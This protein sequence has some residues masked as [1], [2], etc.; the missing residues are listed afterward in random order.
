M[1]TIAAALGSVIGYLGAEVATE[2][3]FERLLWPERYYHDCTLLSTLKLSFLMAMGGPLHRAALGTLQIFQQNGLY[4]GPLRGKMLGTAFY[5][6]GTEFYIPRSNVS[7]QGQKKEVRNCLWIEVL[8]HVKG[9]AKGE[10]FVSTAQNDKK[11]LHEIQMVFQL[12]LRALT[13]RDD[14]A[15]FR[16]IEE[17][18]ITWRV[19]LGIICSELSGIAVAICTAIFFHYYWLTA[20]FCLPLVFKL[21]ALLFR[22]RRQPLDNE[23]VTSYTEDASGTQILNKF[24]FVNVDSRFIVIESP[25]VVFRQFVRHYGHP[26]R[27]GRRILDNEQARLSEARRGKSKAEEESEPTNTNFDPWTFRLD[28]MRPF[29]NIVIIYAFVLYFPAGLL[30]LI[31][32]RNTVQFIWLGYQVYLIFAM[33][34]ARLVGWDSCARMEERVARYLGEGREVCLRSRNGQAVIATLRV[35]EVQ[36]VNDARDLVRKLV[37]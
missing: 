9:T 15:R 37:A 10:S 12:R 36:S 24:E 11:P 16:C 32:E 1:G 33:H 6:C 27:D 30:L 34:V 5:H 25:E 28:Q 2:N 31:W 20:Y 14:P 29:I 21:L 3:I 35:T 23:D 19:L 17:D 13:S 26:L 8:R 22:V 7:D 18:K 4:R